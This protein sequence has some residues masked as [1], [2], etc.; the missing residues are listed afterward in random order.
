MVKYQ[1]FF[2]S[3]EDYITYRDEEIE[4]GINDYN[5]VNV[6]RKENAEVGMHSNVIYSLIDPK[7]LHYR[8]DLFLK[9]FIQD[10][11]KIE[12]FGEIISVEA[13]EATSENRRIDFTIKSTNYY[14]GIEMKIDAK[15]LN[16]QLSHYED[17]LKEKAKKAGVEKVLIYYLTKNGKDAGFH[18]S[19]GIVYKRIS[20]EEHILNW[21]EHCQ[22]E[23]KNITNLNQAFENY[24]D[25]VKKITGKY[26]GNLMQL[27]EF[28]KD[29]N[30]SEFYTVFNEIDE[31]QERVSKNFI[32]TLDGYLNAIDGKEKF[33]SFIDIPIREYVIRLYFNG[34]ELIVQIG[35]EKDRFITSVSEDNREKFLNIYSGAS[36]LSNKKWAKGYGELNLGKVRLQTQDLVLEKAEKFI[37]EFSSI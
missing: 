2:D 11:L 28:L 25:I 18:S 10:V 31:M 24:K 19:E 27:E 14:V 13:E 26:R 3:I 29:Q 12:D 30:V 6:V 21:I 17:D 8:E 4:R 9:L 16:Q 37:N 36:K 15:D 35:N 34:S 23:V 1:N 7:G 20:F 22:T 32:N 33:S 5:M